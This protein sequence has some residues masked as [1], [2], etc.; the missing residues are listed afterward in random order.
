MGWFD[1]GAGTMLNSSEDFAFY[2]S[3][4]S[5]GFGSVLGSSGDVNGDDFSDLT[6]AAPQDDAVY[7][8]FGKP[9]SEHL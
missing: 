7:L 5:G 3:D 9:A 4:Q 2:M 6:V 8:F 1:M